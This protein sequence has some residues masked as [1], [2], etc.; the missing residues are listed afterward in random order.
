MSQREGSASIRETIRASIRKLKAIRD[1][2]G[3]T[4]LLCHDAA[5]WGSTYR[6]LP[7]FYG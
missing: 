1:A 5:A 3:A 2:E 7:D 6:L 4:V